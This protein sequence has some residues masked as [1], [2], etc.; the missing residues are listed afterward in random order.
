MKLSYN[1]ATSMG[2]PDSSLEND[3]R[4]CAA[5]GFELLEFRFDKLDPYLAEHSPEE[6]VALLKDCG[7]RPVAYNALYLYPELYTDGDDL[8]RR[9]EIEHRLEL[10]ASLSSTLGAYNIV[11]VVPL[12]QEKSL[13]PWDLP[14]EYIRNNCIR[15][16]R[17]L[18]DYCRPYGIRLALETVGNSMSAVRTVEKTLEIIALTDRENVGFAADPYNIFQYDKSNDFSALANVPPEKLFVVHINN[19]DDVPLEKI[20]QSD[21]CFCNRGVIDLQAYLDT[22]A[23]LGYDGPVSIELVRPEYW[24]HSTGWV[25][26]EAYRT[27]RKVLEQHLK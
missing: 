1:E 23:T 10:A 14:W 8:A 26:S 4:A 16:L 27:T 3:I 2:C 25:V 9:A 22:I 6:L 21:R 19:A 7:I 15:I 17:K 11:V 13:G 20:T 5:A 24:S 18:S 12:R